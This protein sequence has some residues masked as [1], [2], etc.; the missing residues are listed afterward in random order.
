MNELS[1]RDKIVYLRNEYMKDPYDAF[2]NKTFWNVM[3]S[4]SDELVIKW[5][6]RAVKIK[7]PVHYPDFLSTYDRTEEWTIVNSI[8]HYQ[9]TYN[10]HTQMPWTQSQKR[11]CV[12]A[13]VKYWDDLEIDYYC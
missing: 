5:T 4:I 6:D 13:I 8:V 7:Q 9:K 10:P 3:D 1:F 2:R 11:K 12:W